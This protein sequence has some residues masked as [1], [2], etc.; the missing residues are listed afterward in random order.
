[1][2][3]AAAS[4][5]LVLALAAWVSR[6]WIGPTLHDRMLGAHGAALTACLLSVAL[7]AL[8]ERAD[9]IDVAL[10]ILFAYL[11]FAVAALKL[12]RVRSLQTALTRADAP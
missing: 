10:A 12:F 4:M 9:W 5:I 1:M 7:A 11:V 2:I 6:I 8:V 3:A